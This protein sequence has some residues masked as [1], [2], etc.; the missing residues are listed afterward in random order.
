[1]KPTPHLSRVVLTMLF[2]AVFF[3]VG[4]TLEAASAAALTPADIAQ[5]GSLPATAA[6]GNYV[7]VSGLIYANDTATMEPL[8]IQPTAGGF[9]NPPAGA[10]TYCLQERDTANTLVAEHCFDVVFVDSEEGLRASYLVAL[11]HFDNMRKVVLKKSGTILVSRVL[12]ANA[13]QVTVTSPNGGEI[14]GTNPTETIT[15]TG[16]DADGDPLIYDVSYSPDDGANWY[17]VGKNL[18]DTSLTLGLS[19]LQ[20]SA[21]ARVKVE[22]NDG[23]LIAE[24]QSDGTFTLAK[25]IPEATIANPTNGG[26]FLNPVLLTGSG[27]DPEDGP[28]TGEFLVWTSD[29]DGFLGYDE[30]LSVGLSVG[31][32]TITL[33]AT[34]DDGYTG[35]TSVSIIVE[36]CYNVFGSSS[37]TEGGSVIPTSPGTCNADGDMYLPGTVVTVAATPNMGWDLA[38]WTGTDNDASTAL[39]N[40]VTVTDSDRTATANFVSQPCVALTLTHTGD[41]ADPVASPEYSEGCDPGTYLPREVISLTAAPAL[42]WY[43]SSWTGTANDASTQATNTLTMP[44]SAHTAT[45]NYTLDSTVP[46]KPVLSKP[47]NGAKVKVMWPVLKW[48]PAAGMPFY[49]VQVKDTTGAVVIQTTVDATQACTATVCSYQLQTELTDRQYNWSVRSVTRGGNTSAWS[50]VWTFKYVGPPYPLT[51]ERGSVVTTLTPTF[52]W[53]VPYWLP[54]KYSVAVKRVNPDGS[55]TVVISHSS[56]VGK[57]AKFCVGTIC[58]YTVPIGKL[59]DNTSYVWEVKGINSTYSLISS[60]TFF[61]DLP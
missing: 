47:S 46:I 42:S 3:L 13:P 41:G 7:I 52:T 50:T 6:T 39:T 1:M 55:T 60:S 26:Y 22:V 25:K 30:S 29:V 56:T 9:E 21:T 15:W 11:P 14:W 16:S 23:V 12:T 5:G 20:E 59:K 38:G 40:T 32:H 61:V 19:G 35:T 51:P 34:D 44:S 48:K 31:A 37:P 10:R 27:L 53:R 8:R 49:E 18:T 24:D 57:K 54:A 2:A 28:V 17:Y 4:G 36:D 33:E 45:V 58:S 43:I